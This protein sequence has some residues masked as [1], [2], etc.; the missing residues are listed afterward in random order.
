MT[1]HKRWHGGWLRMGMLAVIIGVSGSAWANIPGASDETRDNGRVNGSMTKLGR[2]IANI[3]TCP[4]ELMR[5]PTLV[6]RKQ[7]Y[8]AGMSVGLGRGAWRTLQRG[9]VG[10]FEVATFFSEVPD[11][12]EPIMRPEFVFAHGDWTDD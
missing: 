9:A 3:V 7:G 2:G 1:R 11:N 8:L 12:F 4:F 5:T 10:L 6:A